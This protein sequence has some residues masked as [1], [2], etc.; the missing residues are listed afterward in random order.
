M[1]STPNAA[2]KVAAALGG[3]ANTIAAADTALRKL[4][5]EKCGQEETGKA[6]GEKFDTDLEI[7]QLRAVITEKLTT[8]QGPE[9]VR[10]ELHLKQLDTI[11]GLS[12]TLGSDP[13]PSRPETVAKLTKIKSII[14]A[15]K[16]IHPTAAAMPQAQPAPPPGAQIGVTAPTVGGG[17]LSTEDLILGNFMIIHGI[18]PG[19][20]LAFMQSRLGASGGY[21]V[22]A[23]AHTYRRKNRSTRSGR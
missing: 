6:F 3:V 17:V 4:E 7:V 11:A 16:S 22:P 14:E 19:V 12:K 23:R 21:D 18:S 9:K 2:L 10:F 8:A 5:K 15:L 1:Q 13:D 20:V